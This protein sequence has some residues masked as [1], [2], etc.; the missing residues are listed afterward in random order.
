MPFTD[1][2]L[3][4]QRCGSPFFF[5]VEQQRQM[6][7]AE[8]VVIDPLLCPTCRGLATSSELP[9]QP[10]SDTRSSLVE[11][12]QATD[13][14]E[15]HL[16]PVK[17]TSVDSGRHTG[18]VKWFDTRKGFGFIV[19]DDGSEIFVHH[20]GIA[21]VGPKHLEDGQP[22]EYEIETTGKGPQA[23]NVF[24]IEPL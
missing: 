1:K 10:G 21:G 20:T 22:V 5:T 13:S 3:H 9:S 23:F 11:S 24:P 19:Q 8:L 4:C 6:D 17:P 16:V 2:V 12:H 14:E 15:V 18:R 7:T